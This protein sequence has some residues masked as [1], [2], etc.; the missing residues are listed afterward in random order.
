MKT[1]LL[2]TYD[3]ADI[4]AQPNTFFMNLT[5]EEVEVLK[6]RLDDAGLY[7]QIK[8]LEEELDDT[9]IERNEYQQEALD[10]ESYNKRYEDLIESF[11]DNE[12][13]PKELRH[14]LR[15]EYVQINR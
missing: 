7:E 4:I 3:I 5:D 12:T 1:H 11:L 2:K 10:H 8:D 9:K 13:V 6:T 15:E 14:E